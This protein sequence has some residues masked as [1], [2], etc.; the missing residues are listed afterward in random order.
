MSF[1]FKCYSVPIILTKHQ[2]ELDHFFFYIWPKTK[3]PKLYWVPFSSPSFLQSAQRIKETST[4]SHSIFLFLTH[5]HFPFTYPYP[6]SMIFLMYS[7]ISGTYSLTRVRTSAG[8]TQFSRK[9]IILTYNPHLMLDFT[10]K[11]FFKILRSL[12]VKQIQKS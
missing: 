2:N 8:K 6:F 5:I 9:P 1:N 12:E 4:S 10:I 3:N 7:T 11:H